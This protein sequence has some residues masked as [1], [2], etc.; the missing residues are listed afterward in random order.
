MTPEA[1]ALLAQHEPAIVV[2]GHSHVYGEQLTNDGTCYINPGSAGPARFKLKRTAALLHLP[3]KASGA[4]PRLQRIDLAGKAPPRLR[5]CDSRK[6]QRAPPGA[7]GSKERAQ[8]SDESR[9]RV[10][11]RKR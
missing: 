6:Q 1:K 4:V 3:A 5:G 10:G 2:L 7:A 9:G 11:K 8:S